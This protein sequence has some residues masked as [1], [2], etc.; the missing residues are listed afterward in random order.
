MLEKYIFIVAFSFLCSTVTFLFGGWDK[1][2]VI[3]LVFVIIDY[4]TGMISAT[5]EGSLSSRIGFKGIMQK[6]FIFALVAIAHLIDLILGEYHF[7]RDTTIFFYLSN[8]LLS[9]IE[10]AGR[11]GV[12]VPKVLTRAIKLLRDRNNQ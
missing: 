5:I 8:E 11:A 3:L 1:L 12:P 10:N 2:M 7:L 6:I 9:I 4:V